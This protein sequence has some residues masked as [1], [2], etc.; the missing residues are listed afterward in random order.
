MGAGGYCL[1]EAA[2]TSHKGTNGAEP[3]YHVEEWWVVYTYSFL[4]YKL[5]TG[6]GFSGGVT[7][8]QVRLQL[9]KEE[10][11]EVH[12]GRATLHE[13]SATGFLAMGLH[14]EHLQ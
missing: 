11:D 8:A 9:R 7:E 5:L 4:P 2:K 3:I 10:T 1:G 6:S 12:E 13:T 14:I